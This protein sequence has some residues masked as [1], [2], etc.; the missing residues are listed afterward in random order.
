MTP[1]PVRSRPGRRFSTRWGGPI[2]RLEVLRT[3]TGTQED[4]DIA[5]F[6]PVGSASQEVAHDSLGLESTA[7]CKLPGSLENE[8]GCQAVSLLHDLSGHGSQVHLFI[9]VRQ[10]ATNGVDQ[11]DDYESK[12]ENRD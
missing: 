11:D 3:R 6:I 10:A 2:D 4:L 9:N 7:K 8:H 5:G 12:T 1:I